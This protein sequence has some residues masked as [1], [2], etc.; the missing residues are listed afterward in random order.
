MSFEFPLSFKFKIGTLSND[1]V[2]TDSK[3]NTVSYVRQKM[4]KLKED[5]MC[6]SNES[7]KTLLYRIKANKWLDFSATYSFF[8]GD[9]IELGKVARKG[10]VSLWKATYVVLNTENTNEFTIREENPWVKV[11]DRLVSEIPIVGIFTGYMFNPSY[12]VTN[13]QNEPIMRFKKDSSFFGRKFSLH[14]LKEVD[15]K[16]QERI[17]LSLMMMVLLERRRG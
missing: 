14:Q 7:K 8:N 3:N 11:L 2:I 13:E 4:F 5:I 10:A 16:A 1:F 12:L 15:D 17:V 6:Y 9:D